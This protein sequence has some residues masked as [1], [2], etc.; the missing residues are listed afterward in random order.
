MPLR[1]LASGVAGFVLGAV[2]A[3]F[4]PPLAMAMA[5]VLLGILV[6][7]RVRHEDPGVLT[8]L[9]AGFLVAVVAYVGLAVAALMG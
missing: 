2:L 4:A 7:A 8:P 3:V 5:L 1:L 9:A 6:W